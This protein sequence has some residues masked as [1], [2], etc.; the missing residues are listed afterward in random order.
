[1]PV[2]NRS[3]SRDQKLVWM[4]R[5][6]SKVSL[7]LV[8]ASYRRLSLLSRQE[9]GIACWHRNLSVMMA[10]LLSQSQRTRSRRQVA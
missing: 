6:R 10:G 9:D 5:R 8:A 1:M 3:S 2:A 4:E 7:Q